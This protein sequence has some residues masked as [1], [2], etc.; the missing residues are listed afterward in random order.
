M[1]NNIWTSK[2]Y[3]IIIGYLASGK[4]SLIFIN[5]NLLSTIIYSTPISLEYL[6]WDG[7]IDARK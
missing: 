4:Q 3:F 7:N 1:R 2:I 5:S 6:I